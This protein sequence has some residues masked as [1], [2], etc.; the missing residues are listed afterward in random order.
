MFTLSQT[1]TL[2][3]KLEPPD[4]D[5][6]AIYQRLEDIKPDNIDISSHFTTDE[7]DNMPQIEQNRYK[8]IK[9][10]YMVMLEFGESFV[11]TGYGISWM[12]CWY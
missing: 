9:L 8:S 3:P 4:L 1:S 2:P 12:F 10:N 11:F 5:M 7:L 6:H